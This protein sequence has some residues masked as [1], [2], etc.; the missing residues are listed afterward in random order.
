MWQASELSSR[1]HRADLS[2]IA[3]TCVEHEFAF[4]CVEGRGITE[5]SAV[6]EK[7]FESQSVINRT[8]DH[9]AFT[10]NLFNHVS[11]MFVQYSASN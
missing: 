8:K 6:D 2:T 9:F 3:F 4:S 1:S 10:Y 7:T 11:V 5:A